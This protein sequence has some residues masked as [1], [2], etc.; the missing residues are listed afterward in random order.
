MGRLFDFFSK[1]HKNMPE[2]PYDPDFEK[3]VIRASICTGERRAGFRNRKTGAFRE[4][5]LVRSQKDLDRFMRIYG[6][7]EIDTEY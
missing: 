7:K 5:M 3:P 6:L 1:K 2:Y 4:V